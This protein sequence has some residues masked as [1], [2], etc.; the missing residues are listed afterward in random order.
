MLMK[1]EKSLFLIFL[2]NVMYVAL[3]NTVLAFLF[4]KVLDKLNNPFN[5]F[6]LITLVSAFLITLMNYYKQ[7]SFRETN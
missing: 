1:N 2:N 3:I 4:I 6:A 5:Y 7:N